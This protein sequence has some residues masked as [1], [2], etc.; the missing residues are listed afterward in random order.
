MTIEFDAVFEQS[1]EVGCVHLRIVPSKIVPSSAVGKR[2][3]ERESLK[4]RE[5][6]SEREGER[7][8]DMSYQP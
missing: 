2:E 5:G 6:E 7:E 1:V 4:E 3:F 8:G